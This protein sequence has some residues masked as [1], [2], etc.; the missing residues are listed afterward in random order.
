M[1]SEDDFIL[2]LLQ[3]DEALDALS[4]FHLR[5]CRFLKNAKK[6]NK[7]EREEAC[8]YRTI[9]KQKREV[10]DILLKEYK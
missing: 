4:F 10:S 6:L 3:F 2:M 7:I 5:A 1:T 9:V 8:R